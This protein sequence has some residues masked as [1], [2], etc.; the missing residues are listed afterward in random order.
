MKTNLNNERVNYWESP[1]YHTIRTIA[2]KNNLALVMTQ[3]PQIK[4]VYAVQSKPLQSRSLFEL[5]KAIAEKL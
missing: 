3:K 4:K 1:S 5:M 2:I